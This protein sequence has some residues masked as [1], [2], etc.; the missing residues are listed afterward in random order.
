M[1]TI[2]LNENEN[3]GY[4][5]SEDLR[6]VA[7]LGVV[8]DIHPLSIDVH[9]DYDSFTKFM[10]DLEHLDV[11]SKVEY[12]ISNLYKHELRYR[13][14]QTQKLVDYQADMLTL[15]KNAYASV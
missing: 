6:V 10:Y 15:I 5:A 14:V 13:F 3:N 8:Y 4:M 7:V 2:T 9:D 1:F 12:E 11:I